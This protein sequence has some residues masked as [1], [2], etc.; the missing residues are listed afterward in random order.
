MAIVATDTQRYS[1]V[2]KHEYMPEIGYCKTVAVVNGPA[3]TI[4]I[5]TVL[6]KV[7]A[8]GKYKV[9]EASANDGSQVAAAVV[10]GNARGHTVPTNMAATTD[11]SFL[12]I[13]RGPA[14]VS[15][16]ALTLGASVTAG[17]LTQAAYAQLAAIG[18]DVLTTI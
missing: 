2:V 13:N 5:G 7:T 12:V 4:G 16:G 6:G 8:T 14:G 11:T 18:I 10:V 9:V 3:A 15:A 17:A 1:N